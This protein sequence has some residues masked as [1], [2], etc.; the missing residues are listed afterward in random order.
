MDISRKAMGV[1][2]FEKNDASLEQRLNTIYNTSK[3][4]VP[5]IEQPV[6]LTNSGLECAESKVSFLEIE[7]WLRACARISEQ[8]AQGRPNEARA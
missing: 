1:Q 2:L 7:D 5:Q 8:I 4:C 6:W 3:H